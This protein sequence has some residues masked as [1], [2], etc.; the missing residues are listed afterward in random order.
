[1][2]QIDHLPRAHTDFYFCC[3]VVVTDTFYRLFRFSLFPYILFE[4][5]REDALDRDRF[6]LLS[7]A[8]LFDEA[9]EG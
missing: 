2:V 7:N 1:M 4:L 6:D 3:S 5:S 9:V 8:F